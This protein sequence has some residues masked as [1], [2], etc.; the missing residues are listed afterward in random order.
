MPEMRRFIYW[1]KN[2]DELLSII[3][4]GT[5]WDQDQV[6]EGWALKNN[7]FGTRE[8]YKELTADGI[9]LVF[10]VETD[11]GRVFLEDNHSYIRLT[12]SEMRI[13]ERL[14]ERFPLEDEEDEDEEED[15]EDK[16]E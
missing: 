3:V 14:N 1:D 16:P 6:A 7:I 15:D 8:E 10:G 2:N 13:E 11:D 9:D 5:N 12:E 4:P